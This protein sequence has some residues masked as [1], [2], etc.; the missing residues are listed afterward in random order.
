MA[1]SGIR[2][3]LIVGYLSEVPPHIV[4][5]KAPAILQTK[6]AHHAQ[7]QEGKNSDC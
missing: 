7:N 2:T 5:Y 4:I 6:Y 1:D 3:P